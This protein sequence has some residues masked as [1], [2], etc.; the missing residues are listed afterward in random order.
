MV[1]S[2]LL[3]TQPQT[4]LF[5]SESGGQWAINPE[6]CGEELTP[7]VVSLSPDASTPWR[8]HFSW[9]QFPYLQSGSSNSNTQTYY[10]CE[11][12]MSQCELNA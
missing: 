3:P 8:S 5:I 11:E 4:G 6:G 7:R 2:S 12:P 9:P 10:P 1:E